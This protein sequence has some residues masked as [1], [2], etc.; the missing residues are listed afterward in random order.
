VSKVATSAVCG[1]SNVR[2]GAFWTHS[3]LVAKAPC[4]NKYLKIIFL[5]PPWPGSCILSCK[6]KKCGFLLK[7]KSS[8]RNKIQP[9]KDA[10]FVR[11]NVPFSVID[12]F[13][14]L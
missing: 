4:Q 11:K 1:M 10:L 8:Q 6:I 5:S 13:A 14:K 9:P 7:K 2:G 12:A 3:R